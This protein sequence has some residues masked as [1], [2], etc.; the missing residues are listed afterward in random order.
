M[1]DVE[2]FYPETLHPGFP[3]YKDILLCNYRVT[4]IRKFN[5]NTML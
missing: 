5:I 1:G 2:F 3:E 4:Q